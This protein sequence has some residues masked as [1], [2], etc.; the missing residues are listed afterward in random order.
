M[1]LEIYLPNFKEIL[2]RKKTLDILFQSVLSL[3][4]L[5]ENSSSYTNQ[6]RVCI[7][8]HFKSKVSTLVQR[9]SRSTDSIQ[10]KLILKESYWSLL[11]INAFFLKIK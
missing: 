8:E 1:K 11:S 5:S 4:R 3:L 6:I 7:G 10:T 2:T 9:N